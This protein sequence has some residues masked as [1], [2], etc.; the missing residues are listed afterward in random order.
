MRGPNLRVLLGVSGSIA[1]YK[2][3][4][5]AR[6]LGQHS[7]S[8]QVAMTSGAVRFVTP[9]TFEA[10]T[11]RAVLDDPWVRRTGEIEHVER[12]HEVDLLVVAPASANTMARLAHGF[13]D[14]PLT[15]IALSTT[16]PILLAPAMEHGMWNHPATQS[17]LHTLQQRGVRI[18]GP[19]TGSL[20]SGRSGD[21][22]ME[23]PERIVE[24]ALSMLTGE[25]RDLASESV[26]ITAGPTWEPIDPVRVL[27]NR[28]TGAMGIALAEE[29][30]RRGAMV[31]LVLGPTHLRP[32]PHPGLT[33]E[34]VETAEQML[35]ASLVD[36]T[37]RTVV[38]GAAAVGDFRPEV[39]REQKWKKSQ[40]DA[41]VLRL[42]ENP[43]VLATLSNRLRAGRP[44][45]IV[46]GFAAETEA[47]ETNARAKLERKGCD[48][49]VGNMVGPDRGFGEGRTRVSVF[50]AEEP[51]AEFGPADK[52][53][54]AS[55]IWDRIRQVREGPDV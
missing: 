21:G 39:R 3:V 6:L 19:A 43:D 32:T 24:V 14:D 28:S 22:R 1:A 37:Q 34:R 2:A 33:V 13:A 30:V 48:L 53:A 46:V 10:I 5:I 23:E 9:L 51:A 27:A 8:V 35:A 55:F 16:S 25:R 49:L 44:D 40:A 15:A 52:R 50:Q 41:S 42:V 7:V 36:L 12:A 45:G 20:A 11:G 29:G 4:S 54:V 31:R 38:I 18:V 47:L 17:N 26:L